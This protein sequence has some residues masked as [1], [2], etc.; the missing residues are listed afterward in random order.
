MY[1]GL[2]VRGVV[3]RACSNEAAI[4]GCRMISTPNAGAAIAAEPAFV[5]FT[6]CASGQHCRLQLTR[7][8]HD[9]FGLGPNVDAKRAASESPAIGAVARMHDQRRT[10]QFIADLA[11]G[12]AAVKNRG[13][14]QWP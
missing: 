1:V 10:V 7:R 5:G 2:H 4:A 6:A 14:D 8:Q 3:E 11:A 12:A 13:H 9:I